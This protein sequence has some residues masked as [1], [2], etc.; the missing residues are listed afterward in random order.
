M[1]SDMKCLF[2]HPDL[3]SVYFVAIH[4]R[5]ITSCI[6]I[7]ADRAH[8]QETG[9]VGRQDKQKAELRF[10]LDAPQPQLSHL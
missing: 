10:S 1:S 5:Y 2:H 6:S 9:L 3:H 7:A 8:F 4:G